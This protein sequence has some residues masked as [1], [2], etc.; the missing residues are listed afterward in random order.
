M[1][2]LLAAV[3]EDLRIAPVAVVM[4]F[5]GPHAAGTSVAAGLHLHV[6]EQGTLPT[7]ELDVTATAQEPPATS[8]PTWRST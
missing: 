5:T 2:R 1:R 8:T 6:D 3:D 7:A 4:L